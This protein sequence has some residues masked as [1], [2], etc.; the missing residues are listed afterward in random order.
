M[1]VVKERVGISKTNALIKGAMNGAVMYNFATRSVEGDYSPVLKAVVSGDSSYIKDAAFTKEM[2]DV[3]LS[4]AVAGNYSNIIKVL[5]ELG[6]DPNAKTEGD[7][8]AMLW[9]AS[10]GHIDLL[11]ALQNVGADLSWHNTVG[12]GTVPW[13]AYDNHDR[14][15]ELF[16][17][18]K[19]LG[20]DVAACGSLNEAQL[21]LPLDKRLTNMSPVMWMTPRPFFPALR[22]LIKEY[23]SAVDTTNAQG[24]TALMFAAAQKKFTMV[25]ELVDLGADVNKR[26][27][28]HDQ[29]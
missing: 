5:T 16:A 29:T 4:I 28:A 19:Q 1:S 18:L 23:D 6:A 12:W 10:G 17:K 14:L 13:A 25:K 20:Q 22:A 26:M 11:E 7:D 27:P 3:A 24:L 8:T 15:I 21:K 2:A 9:A